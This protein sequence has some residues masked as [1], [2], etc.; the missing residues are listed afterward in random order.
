MPK[1]DP[2]PLAPTPIPPI[3][4][5]LRTVC[6]TVQCSACLT[7]ADQVHPSLLQWNATRAHGHRV[8]ASQPYMHQ[9]LPCILETMT[10]ADICELRHITINTADIDFDSTDAQTVLQIH[11]SI[12]CPVVAQV[13]QLLSSPQHGCLGRPDGPDRAPPN[14]GHVLEHSSYPSDDKAP[15]KRRRRDSGTRQETQTRTSPERLAT[16]TT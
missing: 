1:Q 8:Q 10:R 6:L 13:M 12:Q 15:T 7:C 9:L 3:V 16:S 5:R 4:A 14:P 2:E 11:L